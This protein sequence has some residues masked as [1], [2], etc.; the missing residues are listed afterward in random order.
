MA[1]ETE[2]FIP[3]RLSSQSYGQSPRPEHADL[4]FA[5]GMAV[6]DVFINRAIV[7]PRGKP[8]QPIPL[9]MTPR[10]DRS[11][12]PYIINGIKCLHGMHTAPT[13]EYVGFPVKALEQA[14]W[15][16]PEDVAQHC[17]DAIR[18]ALTGTEYWDVDELKF[19]SARR[20]LGYGDLVVMTTEIAAYQLPWPFTPDKLAT[21]GSRVGSYA[22][23]CAIGKQELDGVQL[24]P[25]RYRYS[26]LTHTLAPTSPQS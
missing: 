17:V 5:A 6:A 16:P 1:S 14:R 2:P 4:A 13:A 24:T 21:Y 22:L 9:T 26:P 7:G 3:F 18:L 15:A 20:D 8:L 25:H 10:R 23:T 19:H 12:H 11:G